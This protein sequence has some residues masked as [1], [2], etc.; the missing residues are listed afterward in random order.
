MSAPRAEIISH[1]LAF[2]VDSVKTR[3]RSKWTYHTRTLNKPAFLNQILHNPRQQTLLVLSDLQ[4]ERSR[5]TRHWQRTTIRQPPPPQNPLPVNPAQ[6]LPNALVTPKA[7]QNIKSQQKTS[8]P[9]RKVAVPLIPSLP[10][11]SPSTNP[12]EILR[13]RNAQPQKPL[14]K[15]FPPA[16]LPVPQSVT[17]QPPPPTRSALARTP[18]NL[19]RC[20]KK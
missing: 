14:P 8:A 13:A 18:P 4:H 3:W 19:Q 9:P 5:Q 12:P 11:L 20:R 1:P 2:D 17:V 16:L 10:P 6:S 7:R 15:I